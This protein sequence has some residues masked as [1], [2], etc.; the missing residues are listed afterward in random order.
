METHKGRFK[1]YVVQKCH[2]L[3]KDQEKKNAERKEKATEVANVAKQEEP[4][5]HET[6][7]NLVFTLATSTLSPNY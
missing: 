1:G 2:P 4:V 6:V 3:K 5:I 7:C